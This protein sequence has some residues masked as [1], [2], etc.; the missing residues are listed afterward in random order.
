MTSENFL[1]F[2]GR[3]CSAL[4]SVWNSSLRPSAIAMASLDV[5]SER[6]MYVF[7]AAVRM[8]A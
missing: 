4:C 2:G 7:D 3:P 1:D 5:F 6:Q 8:R